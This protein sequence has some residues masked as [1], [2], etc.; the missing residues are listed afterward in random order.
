MNRLQRYILSSYST[1]F[2]QLFIIL[3]A[4]TSIIFLVKIATDTSLLKITFLDL[5]FLYLLQTPLIIFFAAPISFFASATINLVR[6]SLDSELVVFFSFGI[7]P[8]QIAK[9]YLKVAL[10]ISI[11]MLVLSIGAIP[12]TQQLMYEFINI[13]KYEA[14]LNVKSTEFG[15]SFGEWLLFVNSSKNNIYSDVVMMS[16]KQNTDQVKFI[17][18]DSTQIAKTD[19][20]FKMKLKNG[21]VNIIDKDVITLVNYK[22]LHLNDIYNYQ[23]F[24]FL[25]ITHYWQRYDNKN[26]THIRKDLL[27]YILISIFPILGIFLIM[28]LGVINP[29]LNKNNTNIYLFIS[30]IVYF[31]LGNSL[32]FSSLSTNLIM[33]PFGWALITYYFYRK[34]ILKVF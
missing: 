3:Y 16:I 22:E 25:D 7:S 8:N 18:S 4:I 20:I 24:S 31:S 12:I 6:L 34:K 27:N 17:I 9:I 33:F 23:R 29:R 32:S 14:K 21:E 19:N 15:Q 5:G 10:L 30:V 11:S 2:F 1:L 26:Y 13:K 28:T